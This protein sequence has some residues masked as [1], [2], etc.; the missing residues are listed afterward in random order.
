MKK[1]IT[2]TAML[3]SRREQVKKPACRYILTAVRVIRYTETA[4]LHDDL[5]RDLENYGFYEAFCAA[6]QIWAMSV[7][8]VPPVKD[9]Y[10]APAPPQQER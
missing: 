7:G 9:F 5:I 1:R 6:E 4:L 2:G 10:L 8:L 3:A